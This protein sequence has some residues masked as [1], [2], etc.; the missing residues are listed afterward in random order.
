MAVIRPGAP[1]PYARLVGRDC[2]YCG[3]P[4][5]PPAVAWIGFGSEELVLHPD[6]VLDLFVRLARDVWEIECTTGRP[7][8]V[9]ALRHE[10][11][12]EERRP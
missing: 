8:T 2:Y 10:I 9:L 12:R 3:H 6:C 11:E 1:W 7:T 4:V 5:E